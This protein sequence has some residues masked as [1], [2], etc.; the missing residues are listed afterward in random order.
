MLPLINFQKDWLSAYFVFIIVLIFIP[1]AIYTKGYITE[2]KKHYSANYMLVLIVLF[3]A[4]MIGVVVSNNSI[5]FLIFWELM[6]ISSFFLVIY[7]YMHKE[8]LKAGIFY[9]VMTHIS[10]LFLM[11]M[12]AFLYKYTGSFD[13][14]EIIKVSMNFSSKQKYI[15][16]ILALFGFGAKMGIVPLHAWLPKAHPTAPS[17]VSALMSGVMLKVALYGFIRIIFIFLKNTPLNC[18][19]IVLIVGTITAIFSILNALLQNNI[20]KLLAYSSAENV[21]LIFAALGISMIL[22]NYN[23][24]MLASLA[25]TAALLHCLCHAIFKSLLFLNAGSVLYATGTKNMNELGGLNKKMKF[26]AICTFIGT[27]AISAV[28]PFNGFASEILI[29]RSFIE[30]ITK[31]SNIWII[32][33]IFISGII[34]ALTSGAAFY[35]TVKSF[36][37]TFLGKP[38]TNKA[39]H[40]KNIPLSMDI[41]QGLLAMLTIVTGVFSPYIINKI[42]YF[43]NN[44]MGISEKGPNFKNET[45]IIVFTAILICIT[46]IVYM[47]NKLNSLNKKQEIGDTWACGYSRDE[48]Y[49]Q[50]TGN[51]FVQPAA[52]IF[53]TIANYNKKVSYK[54]NIHISQTTSDIV[55]DYL[56]KPILKVVNLLTTKILKINYGKIQLHILYIFISIIIALV[57]VLKFV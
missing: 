9:F 54:Q 4:S 45:E 36:G 46:F 35:A 3:V 27:C 28:P 51:G 56:Y 15:I 24:K 1:V 53:G 48:P 42:S 43:T 34:V 38:R 18:G 12:F 6:S 5:S 2:Y 11:I 40:V 23:L 52:K 7:E 57:L 25:L 49:I 14:N 26:T 29:L 20:K 37:I 47:F 19:V 17:N 22:I 44:L 21:G 31:V 30:A 41:G 33:L 16:F 8:N 10:G 32:I 55:E 39:E 50:Y 13:F